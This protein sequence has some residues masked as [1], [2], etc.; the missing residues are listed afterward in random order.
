MNLWYSLVSLLPFEWAEPG[1]MLF[2][3][4]ALL[5]VLVITPL[6]GL[7]STMVV[8]SRMAFFS[9]ALG[10][11]AFTGIAIGAL[12][13][14][15]QPMWAAVV[16]SVIIALLFTLVRQ[17]TKMASDTAISVFSSA[18]V[19]LGMFEGPIGGVLYSLVLGYFADMAFVENTVLFTLLFP[20]LAFA[21]G[22]IAQFFIN[23]RFFAYMGAAL[24]GLAITAL[25]QMLHTST[26]DGF[27]G[28]MLSTVLLQTLWSLPLAA[29]AYIFP[30]R[31]SRF[32]PVSK[33]ES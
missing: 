1:T 11:S 31:W 2:M 33:G 15:T 24:L 22:F 12:C 30:A 27:S 14:L 26:M 16:F 23:R 13:G 20:A 21:A 28:A 7:L 9:D 18:A 19:A 3:K 17:Q 25:G 4:N 32:A 10:H 5:G 6:F 8:E 29:L